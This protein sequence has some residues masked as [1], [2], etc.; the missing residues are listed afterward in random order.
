MQVE[1]TDGAHTGR[2]GFLVVVSGPSAAGKN[3]LL[4]AVIPTLPDAVYSVSAT[5]R[6]PRPGEVH[7]RDYFFLTEEEFEARVQAG[8]FLEWATFVG[9]RYGTPLEFV[10]QQLVAG[11]AVLMDI[12]IQG[13]AQVRA[14]MP[15]AVFVFVLP[16][17]LRILKE[18]I[19]ARGKDSA[20]AIAKRMGEA[21]QELAR[22]VDYDYVV[23]NENLDD[24]AAQL[25]A[26]IVAERCRVKRHRTEYIMARFFSEG[27]DMSVESTVSRSRPPQGG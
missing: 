5:T 23:F 22:L 14:R 10:E 16:P 4:N 12:D 9:H 8:A 15:E 7:G 11:N 18:R 21:R 19:I 2:R 20:E 17:T 27:G 26:I 3:T 13:A 1:G 25:R 6:P 24:A